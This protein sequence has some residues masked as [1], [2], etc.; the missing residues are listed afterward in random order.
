MLLTPK[1]VMIHIEHQSSTLLG[2]TKSTQSDGESNE[3]DGRDEG[4]SSKDDMRDKEEGSDDDVRDK[5]EGSEDKVRDKG[6]SGEDE[7][8]VMWQVFGKIKHH[9]SLRFFFSKSKSLLISSH[10]SILVSYRHL[11]FSYIFTF[12]FSSHL[13]QDHWPLG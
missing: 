10:H 3:D 4:E 7:G 13:H 11:H 1:S 12:A 8:R 2:D 5:G 6:E 9:V